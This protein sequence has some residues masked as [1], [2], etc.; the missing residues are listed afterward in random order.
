MKF[1]KNTIGSDLAIGILSFATLSLSFFSYNE[2]SQNKKNQ[3]AIENEKKI[4]DHQFTEI[5][6]SLDNVKSENDLINEELATA[7]GKIISLQDSLRLVSI[8][9]SSILKFKEQLILVAQDKK[10]LIA[11]VDS[12][13]TQNKELLVA[14]DI[15]DSELLDQKR[16]NETLQQ[17]NNRLETNIKKAS[18]VTATAF[19]ADGIRIRSNGK[20]VTENR[21]RRINKVRVCFTMSENLFAQPGEKEIYI[22]ILSPNNNIIGDKL[23]ANFK[24]SKK[25]LTYSTKT[26]INY[27]N[28]ALD[29]C[30]FVDVEK[31]ELK[32]GTY[33]I[34]VFEGQTKI[35][36]T[37][38][39]LK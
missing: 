23:D 28:K 20:I 31:K 9:V 33:F 32:K 36:D 11:L 1:L 12:L 30:L 16:F 13:D 17:T 21:H 29:L 25:V 27:D 37:Q 4:I 34:N 38:L 8:D 24:S 26:T 35:G 19:K 6:N 39:I 2:Y 10:R 14:L 5:I 18:K 7:K 15:R 3:V 22:Q